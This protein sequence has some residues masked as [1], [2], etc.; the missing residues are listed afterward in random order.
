MLTHSPKAALHDLSNK[1]AELALILKELAN[2]KRLL[3]LCA[4][5]ESGE[6]TVAS[7]AETVDLSQSAL[8]QHLARLRDQNMVEFRREGTTFYYRVSDR[9]IALVL[10]NLKSLYC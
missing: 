1:A 3:I 7:L 8:S 5:L 9:K 2:E 10:K 6:C 4:L